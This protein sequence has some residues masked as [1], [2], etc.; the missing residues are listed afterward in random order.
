MDKF[1][2]DDH[3]LAGGPAA[4]KHHVAAYVTGAPGHQNCS[5]PL[6]LLACALVVP[7]L[8]CSCRLGRHRAFLPPSMPMLRF[9]SSCF[10]VLRRGRLETEIIERCRKH[11]QG[12][13]G[14]Q[15]RVSRSGARH[16]VVPRHQGYAERDADGG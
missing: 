8:Q 7:M 11:K 4:T 6:S 9:N 16:P 12:E 5:S 2:K 1:V 13:S 14:S 3:G 10:S 15:G